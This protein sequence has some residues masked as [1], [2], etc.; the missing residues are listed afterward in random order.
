MIDGSTRRELE[1]ILCEHKHI[2]YNIKQRRDE[3]LTPWKEEDENKGIKTSLPSRVTE[4]KALKLEEDKCYQELLKEKKIVQELFNYYKND[5]L[6]RDILI[7]KYNKQNSRGEIISKLSIEER[8]YH[9]W[10]NEAL[11]QLYR[12]YILHFNRMI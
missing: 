1:R 6:M 10:I 3:V 12:Y 4:N 7:L 2:D 11:E 5:N 9:R 8:A